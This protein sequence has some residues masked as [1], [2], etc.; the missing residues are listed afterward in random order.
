M[1]SWL[2]IVVAKGR[3]LKIEGYVNPAYSLSLTLFPSELSTPEKSIWS[4]ADK[5]KLALG[6]VAF[7]CVNVLFQLNVSTAILISSSVPCPCD[8]DA[9]ICGS[10][11]SI[12]WK[13]DVFFVV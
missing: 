5:I 10:P 6:A 3:F 2:P 7:A 11:T 13:L 4:P 1:L 8:P 9:P 12:V